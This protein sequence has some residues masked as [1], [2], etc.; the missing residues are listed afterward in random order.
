MQTDTKLWVSTIGSIMILLAGLLGGTVLNQMMSGI[1][2]GI[3]N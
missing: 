1:A 2:L 3:E